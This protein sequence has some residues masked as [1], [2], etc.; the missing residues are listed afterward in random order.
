MNY[1]HAMSK[2][3]FYAQ[4]TAFF[5]SAYHA[6]YN[7]SVLN[8]FLAGVLLCLVLAGF[9]PNRIF[10]FILKQEKE[11]TRYFYIL[12]GCNGGHTNS[13]I[14]MRD[15]KIFNESEARSTVAAF[16]KVDFD[17]VYVSHWI[18]FDNE[19][20]YKDFTKKHSSRPTPPGAE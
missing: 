2:V 1:R 16:H 7:N 12:L 19:Q 13:T 15:G 14:V 17:T 5:A 8:A 9:F 4:I 20:D 3:W 18:E 11:S 6:I 10:D